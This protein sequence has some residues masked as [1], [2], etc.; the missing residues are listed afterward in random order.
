MLSLR[1]ALACGAPILLLLLLLAV[2]VQEERDD[3]D[4]AS[5]LAVNQTSVRL[6]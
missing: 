4:L 3:E 2:R 1:R 6:A 5:A